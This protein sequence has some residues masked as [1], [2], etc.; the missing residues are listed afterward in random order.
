M[1]S[2]STSIGNSKYYK[3][4]DV[5]K[6]GL[7]ILI[8]AAHT[9]LF[10]EFPDFHYFFGIFC[11]CAIPTFF[12]VSSFLFMKRLE[13]TTGNADAKRV[14]LKT[15]KRL[16]F[17]FGIWYLLML[18]M[19]YARFWETATLKESIYALF[20]SCSFN[21]YWFFKTLIINTILLYLFRK[22]KAL[23]MLSIFGL[24]IYLFWAYNYQYHYVK[25][26]ISPYYSFFYHIFAFCIGALYAKKQWLSTSTVP[27]LIILFIACTILAS[28]KDFNPVG[29][30]L[31]PIILLPLFSRLSFTSITTETCR[32]FRQYSILFYVMQFVLIWIYDLACSNYLFEYSS[33][34]FLNF[35]VVR[36][37]LITTTLFMFSRLFLYLE[38][39]KNIAYL[40]L[41]H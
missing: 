14:L 8:V 10:E 13:L 27:A 22:G 17:I 32:K 39:S 29:R 9:R 4:F 15:V 20:F 7:A 23:T 28:I 2:T 5:L 18:P 26:S 33:L 24:L 21:G 34:S 12:A 36:F 25:W 31:Y 11:S 30:I 6:F 38:E 40:K 41:M 1:Y 37:G 19:S 16:F 3:G 35:S